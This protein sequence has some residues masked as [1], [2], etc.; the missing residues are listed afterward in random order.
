M[1]P[2]TLGILLCTF[3]LVHFFTSIRHYSSSWKSPDCRVWSVHFRPRSKTSVA[4]I[5]KNATAQQSWRN[6]FYILEVIHSN[7][8][9]VHTAMSKTA[10]WFHQHA[11]YSM[12]NL[13]IWLQVYITQLQQTAEGSRYRGC[14]Q[15][16]R[17]KWKLT[18]GFKLN[19]PY[20][21]KKGNTGYTC[22]TPKCENTFKWSIK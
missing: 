1:R 8:S 10:K 19:K 6:S 12:R 18:S 17:G 9:Q 15:Y 4:V 13:N 7:M 20:D 22:K 11:S 14:V 5:T 21:Q 2:T 3:D 16:T